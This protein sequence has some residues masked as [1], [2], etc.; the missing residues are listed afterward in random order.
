MFFKNPKIVFLFIALISYSYS[1]SQIDSKEAE[2]E[3]IKKKELQIQ[4]EIDSLKLIACGDSLKGIGYPISKNKVETWEHSAMVIGFSCEEKLPAWVFHVITP[5]I[6]SGNV[7]RKDR[8]R[9]DPKATC[10]VGTFEDYSKTSIIDGKKKSKSYGY[11][12]G[13]LAP[14]ADFK[15]SEIALDESFYYTNMT[16]QTRDFNRISWNNLESKVR[17]SL[18]STPCNH[19]VVTGPI[20]NDYSGV[21]G[22]TNDIPVPNYFYKAIV[23]LGGKP[24]GIGFIMPNEKCEKPLASYI[25][26]IDSIEKLTGLNLFPVIDK[27]LQDKIEAQANFNDWNFEIIKGDVSPID[28]TTLPKGVFNTYQAQYKGGETVQV[29]GKVVSTYYAEKKSGITFI[30]LDK[31]YPNQTFTIK[32]KKE[33]LKNFSYTPHIELKDKTVIVIGKV[34]LDKN[35]LPSITITSEKQIEI[36]D[37]KVEL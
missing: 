12:R 33:N 5:D 30:N 8:F 1:F 19:Y 6:L 3:Q 27:E 23:R 10:I 11:D 29:A 34:I 37:T 18:E 28:P 22:G 2:L 36:Y 32:I 7:K 16:A 21:T 26:T 24:S 25:V 20:L 9:N 17:Q 15:W 31:D 14:S 35:R 4:H 13:H